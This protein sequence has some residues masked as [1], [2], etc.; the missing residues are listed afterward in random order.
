MT[1]PK[2]H[3]LSFV[4][5]D[6]DHLDEQARAI[7]SIYDGRQT[8]VVVRG[9]FP[10]ELVA[11][12]VAHLGADAGWTSPNRG[13]AGG[14]IRTIGDAATPTFTWLRGPPSEVYEQS[15]V[16]H[17]QR[18]EAVFGDAGAPTRH[19]KN[20]L[21]SLFGGR[22]ADPPA[23]DTAL[24][25]APYNFRALDP[26][27]QIYAHHDNHY[28]LS[29][30]D[31]MDP[32][33]DRTTLL[34]FFVTLQAPEGGGTLVVYGVWG[35]DPDVPVLPTRFLDTATIE[36]RYA[37]ADVQLGAGDLVVFDAGRH[38]HRVTAVEGTRSRLTFG[39]FLTVARDRDR[40]A[41]WS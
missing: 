34:S 27:Q 39:G 26:G 12:A 8:G 3:P 10:P 2:G 4:E 19:L 32:G 5:V 30:Y 16:H 11:A 28:G 18:T 6:V 9:A 29:I 38:V 24:T 22:P 36:Q 23:F 17:A 31:R 14:E 21:S 20:L 15:A 37:R 25:W 13:M 1:T 33:L 7:E 35:S 41:F 40:L